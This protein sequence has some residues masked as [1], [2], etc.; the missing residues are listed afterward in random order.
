MLFR[1]TLLNILLLYLVFEK[2]MYKFAGPTRY[3]NI[4]CIPI[5]ETKLPIAVANFLVHGEVSSLIREWQKY[6]G[7]NLA[8]VRGFGT[9]EYRHMMGHRDPIYLLKWI[10]ILMRIH[11]YAR[12]SDFMILFNRI[13]TLNT[14][15]L[16]E[17]FLVDVFKGEAKLLLSE[18]LKN[19]MELGV[20][21]VKS[22]ARSEERRVGKECRL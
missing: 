1:S 20:S 21:T 17:E 2:L 4:F 18:D 8:P 16:Y 7:L 10:N 6:S 12:K 5:Q 22:I 11:K 9:V 13:R 3:K 15:S 19:D 14:T